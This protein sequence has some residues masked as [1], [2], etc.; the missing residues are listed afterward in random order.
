MISTNTI[1]L[2]QSPS[3]SVKST[4]TSS[5]KSD[6]LSALQNASSSQKYSG[7]KKTFDSATFSNKPP[8]LSQEESK[9]LA[10]KY[11]MQDFIR[12]DED[13]DALLAELVEKGIFTE[14]E[15]FKLSISSHAGY[16]GESRNIFVDENYPIP[17]YL[18]RLPTSNEYFGEAVRVIL[19]AD[20]IPW[21]EDIIKEMEWDCKI[22]IEDG[23]KE[24]LPDIK[25][26]IELYH[27]FV[28]ILKQIQKEQ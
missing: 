24:V 15:A 7:V 20:T 13:Q 25:K 14:E 8:T 2:L 23:R 27:K 12:N 10:K 5:N 21:Y 26:D 3:A 18:E 17:H 19:Y 9:E 6:F 1:S 11:D 28:K 4:R 22:A 16:I